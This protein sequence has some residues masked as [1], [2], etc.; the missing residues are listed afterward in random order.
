[1]DLIITQQTQLP[2]LEDASH[3]M[4]SDE[5]RADDTAILMA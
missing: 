5:H 4:F 3:E 1:M 2:E